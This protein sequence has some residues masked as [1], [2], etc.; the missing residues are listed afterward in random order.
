MFEALS[1]D[2]QQ[3]VISADRDIYDLDASAAAAA[4]VIERALGQ[5]IGKYRL[6]DHLI[7][8]SMP[9]SQRHTHGSVCKNVFPAAA[10]TDMT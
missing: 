6:H 4:G 5:V 10:M 9:N 1:A 8:F 3:D 7:G 2:L